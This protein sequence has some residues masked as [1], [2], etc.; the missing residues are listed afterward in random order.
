MKKLA[1]LTLSLF[2]CSG[3]AFADSPKGS[4]TA[5]PAKDA[6]PEKAKETAKT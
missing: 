4:P 6:Q 3:I 2:L 1:A 5:K